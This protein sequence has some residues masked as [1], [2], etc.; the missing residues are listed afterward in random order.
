MLMGTILTAAIIAYGAPGNTAADYRLAGIEPV[1]TPPDFRLLMDELGLTD[2]DAD[3]ASMLMDDYADSMRSVLA[4]LG[5]QRA[6][7]RQRLDLAI[8]G[9]IRISPEELRGIRLS[10]RTAVQASW[11]V[12]DG[13]LAELV[14]WATLIS[15]LTPE[16]QHDAIAQFHRRVFLRESSNDALV[17]LAR[18]I[19]AGQ[20]EELDG[21]PPEQLDEALQQWK[22]AAAHFAKEDALAVRQRRLADDVASLRQQT[23]VRE[24]LSKQ[25]AQGWLGRMRV[26][27]AGTDAIAVVIVQTKGSE[28]AATWRRRVRQ[29]CFPDVSGNIDAEVAARWV[30]ANGSETQQHD[31]ARCLA[32]SQDSLESLRVEAVRLLREGRSIGVDLAHEAAAGIEKASQLRMQYLRN[33]GERSLLAQE[34]LDCV[35]RGLT[36]G[37][38]AAIRRVLVAGQ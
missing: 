1:V 35:Q 15:P 37:Q 34:V 16:A 5:Q 7:D 38:R 24:Q 6:D 18:L 13:K 30:I 9:R 22:I 36:E 26:H 3:T 20:T 17:D 14:E 12:A 4:E 23:S 11:T 8:D 28:A 33:S 2:Q 29:A 31:A 25:A 32:Q 10:L 19:E 27:D 21:L